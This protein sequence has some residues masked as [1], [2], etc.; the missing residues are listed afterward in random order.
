MK[1]IGL[2]GG[3]SWESTSLYYETIN[4]FIAGELGG[5][6]SAEIVMSSVDFHF[7]ER[8][9][10]EGRWR[11]AGE[12]LAQRA[13]RLEQAGADFLVL[14]TNT[15]HKVAPRIEES[16]KIPL[17][18]I[19]DSTGAAVAARSISVVGL[20]GTRF[21]MEE[22]FCVDRLRGRFGLRVVTPDEGDRREIDRV[23]FEEL[24]RGAVREESRA[25]YRR[26]V[27]DLAASGCEGVILACTEIGLLLTAGDIDVPLFDSAR[28]HAKD[29]GAFALGQIRPGGRAVR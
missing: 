15:M 28:I 17:L 12:F 11:E 26:V 19:T 29:A 7:V 9:Q 21:T 6:H 25:T 5:L 10:T 8:L 4:R 13:Q 20:L 16:L 18:H 27:G 24:C 1:T 14:C 3:M 2:L 23:I 22:A